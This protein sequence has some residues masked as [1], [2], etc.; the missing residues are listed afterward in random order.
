MNEN[1]SVMWL[2]SI[3]IAS[4]LILA[5]HQ[6]SRPAM[7][8][9][10]PNFCLLLT[11]TTTFDHDNPGTPTTDS[12]LIPDIADCLLSYSFANTSPATRC[13]ETERRRPL[14]HR[15]TRNLKQQP[16]LHHLVSHTPLHTEKSIVQYGELPEA[17]ESWRRSVNACRFELASHVMATSINT[18]S[19]AYICMSRNIWS[20]LQGQGPGAQ[21]PN[22]C[23][24]EDPS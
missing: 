3:F 17:R 13:S 2:R 4:A 11:T 20:C 21:W 15:P 12:T 7:L 14:I 18:S 24:E 22:C 16:Y 6:F 5:K 19:R 9:C 10:A 23:A 1:D 8:T